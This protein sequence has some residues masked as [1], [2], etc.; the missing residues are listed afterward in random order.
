MGTRIVFIFVNGILTFPGRANNWNVRAVT[1]V[2]AEY[3]IYG[4]TV[5]YFTGPLFSRVVLQTDRTNKLVQKLRS[6]SDRG[7]DIHLVVHSNGGN[8]AVSSLQKLNWPQIRSLH[9]I[10]SAND[11][12]FEKSGL[13]WALE[14][15]RIEQIF[16]Y[17]GGKDWALWLASLSPIQLLFGYG[18][19][20]RTGPKMI[21]DTAV[22]KV[23]VYYKH[24]FG[25]GTWFKSNHFS[26]LIRN[27]V[28]QS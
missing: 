19:L 6:Y 4:E 8:V 24:T 13:N 25:H 20:G 10:S 7:W 14:E 12:N 11:A 18:S 22:K 17:M 26:D 27:I 3:R 1:Q 16:L 21:S 28:N 5:E 23:T 15:G 9:F 2:Q